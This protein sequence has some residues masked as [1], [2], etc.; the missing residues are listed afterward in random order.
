ML[1]LNLLHYWRCV[2]CSAL[3]VVWLQQSPNWRLLG[4]PES[5]VLPLRCIRLPGNSEVP[6]GGADLSEN[7]YR[8][9]WRAYGNWGEVK[10]RGWCL[11]R[12]PSEF[13][14][15]GLTQHST[16]AEAAAAIGARFSK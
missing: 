3:D 11:D 13:S 16:A 6:Q 8:A 5:R 9:V 14:A 7:D 1:L 15:W 12:L 4:G 2:C 10:S